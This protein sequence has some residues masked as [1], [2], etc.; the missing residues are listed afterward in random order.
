MITHAVSAVALTAA[1]SQLANRTTC[2]SSPTGPQDNRRVLVRPCAKAG[3]LTFTRVRRGMDGEHL[4]I[5]W[6]NGLCLAGNYK[7]HVYRAAARPSP[8]H[9]SSS[10]GPWTSGRPTW[11]TGRTSH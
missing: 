3:R 9:G 2:L 10:A 7:G 1:L 8:P 5:S 4:R 6:K 11:C